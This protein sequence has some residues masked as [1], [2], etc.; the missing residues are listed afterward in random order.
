MSYE[1]NFEAKE[2][3]TIEVLNHFPPRPHQLLRSLPPLGGADSATPSQATAT[4]RKKEE[5]AG[6]R[7]GPPAIGIDLGTTHCCV[8]VWRQ[9]HV[10]IIPND[11]DNRTTPSCVA[12]TDYGR[13]IGDAAKDHTNIVFGNAL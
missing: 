6:N 3:R 4:E 2:L 11:Q 12:F 5:M 8:G 10:E 1:R 9:N 7:E 13:L